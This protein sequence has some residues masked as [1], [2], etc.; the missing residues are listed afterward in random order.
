MQKIVPLV[1]I[2]NINIMNE[3][4]E[5]KEKTLRAI[6]SIIIILATIG[7]GLAIIGMILMP[8]FEE[9]ASEIQW[10][11]FFIVFISYFVTVGF[12]YLF[13]VLGNISEKLDIRER[14]DDEKEDLN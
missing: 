10:V 3:I 9:E 2:I 12:G 4:F 7:I 11:T 5:T 13:Q 6:G 14:E 8:I 1:Q